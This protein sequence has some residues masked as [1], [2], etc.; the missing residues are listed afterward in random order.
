MVAFEKIFVSLFDPKVTRK[1]TI[2]C[3]ILVVCCMPFSRLRGMPK[4]NE[5]IPDPKKHPPPK[6]LRDSEFRTH[7]FCIFNVCFH[8]R[9]AWLDNTPS[10]SNRIAHPSQSSTKNQF[11]P[12][13]ITKD[14]LAIRRIASLVCSI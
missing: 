11:P 2:S 7:L 4:Q 6:K 1:N 5:S 14:S 3:Q 9:L 13:P 8:P 10:S 12:S